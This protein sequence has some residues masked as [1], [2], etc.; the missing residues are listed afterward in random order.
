[1]G[2]RELIS[3]DSASYFL[4]PVVESLDFLMIPQ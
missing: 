3:L 2:K 1:V 4:L